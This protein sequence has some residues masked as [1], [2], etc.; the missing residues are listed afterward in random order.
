MPFSN[1]VSEDI[2]LAVL[3]VLEEDPGYAHNEDVLRRSIEFLGHKL[4]GDR[5]RSELSWLQE[6]GLLEVSEVGPIWVA[7]LT[8]RGEDVALGRAR[9][10]GVRR[11]RL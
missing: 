11:P 8:S 4:S 6:Q 9:V 5:M 10:P 1:A 7:K 3:E 2:R